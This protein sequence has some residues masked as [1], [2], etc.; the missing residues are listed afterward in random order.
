MPHNHMMKMKAPEKENPMKTRGI[1]KSEPRE[2]K[3]PKASS[4]FLKHTQKG[5][6]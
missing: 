2:Q 3:G 4:G 5:K 1:T 6:C